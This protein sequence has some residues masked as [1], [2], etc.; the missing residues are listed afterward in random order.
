L[1]QSLEPNYVQGPTLGPTLGPTVG[2]HRGGPPWG[3]HRGAQRAQAPRFDP[4]V[5]SMCGNHNPLAGYGAQWV[6]SGASADTAT[7]IL[8]VRK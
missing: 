1:V 7:L 3:P 6:R 2:A 5:V 4:H 8:V